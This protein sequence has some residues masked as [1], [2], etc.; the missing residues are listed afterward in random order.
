[1]LYGFVTKSTINYPDID[2]NN[3]KSDKIII[4]LLLLSDKIL[5]HY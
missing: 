3:R 4:I 2:G 5:C 1:M